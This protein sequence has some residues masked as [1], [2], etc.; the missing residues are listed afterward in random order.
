MRRLL[1][2]LAGLAGLALVVSGPALAAGPKRISVTVGDPSG[3]V[4]TT[5]STGF[6]PKL[7]AYWLRRQADLV[8]AK[9]T[10]KRGGAIPA[11]T[12]VYT[13]APKHMV[14]APNSQPAGHVV[15]Q[16]FESTLSG[17]NWEIQASNSDSVRVF[18]TSS[19]YEAYD[20]L[21]AWTNAP[22]GGR[23]VTVFVPLACLA[24]TRQTKASFAPSAVTTI[25]GL[26]V[27]T[28][29]GRSRTRVLSLR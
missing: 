18:D 28:D 22:A 14:V 16:L 15:Q 26:G 20:C 4:V 5:S 24:S 2:P 13:L 6:A 7:S 1:T 8:S 19:D 12:I 25:S 10:F 27:Y 23:K 29:R 3:D 21:Q 11:L 9:Y 17:S